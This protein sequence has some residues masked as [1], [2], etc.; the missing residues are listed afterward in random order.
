MRDFVAAV[1]VGIVGGAPVLDLDYAEDSA[2]GTD[3]NVVMTGARRLRR[4]AG[5]RRR[6]AVL[7]RASWTRC[8]ASPTRASRELIAAPASARPRLADEAAGAR[9][10]ATRGKL[11]ELGAAARA[12]RHRGGAAGASSASP[13]PT[14]RTPPSS[15]TRSPRRATRAAPRGLPALADDSGLCVDALGGA[16]G[17]HSARYAGRE[18]GREQ[19][20]ARNNAKL[21][22]ALAAQPTARAHYYCV[23]VLVRH[24]DDPRAADRRRP[25]AR[26]DRRARRAAATAS[27]TTRYFCVPA[28]GKTAAELDARAEE[29][30]QPSRRHAPLREAAGELLRDIASRRCSVPRRP[31][32]AALPPLSL[33]VHLPWCVRKCP[34]CDFNS[35][36]RARRAARGRVRR[37]AASPTSR[38]RCRSVW[39]RR[40]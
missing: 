10:A 22:A 18:G 7:A 20:D 14:S 29:P 12:A 39:G 27:A 17:V 8:S 21:L 25:L 26:R 6:R 2:C 5:H 37:R 34:Y 31:R 33:Y 15:R 35:H 30:R 24:A 23:L 38:P 19:R 32:F 36:E 3:M 28:L 11:R 1:S 4:G 40:V 9:V 13:R 16:P